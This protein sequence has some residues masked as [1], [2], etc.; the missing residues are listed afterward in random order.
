MISVSEF[1]QKVKLTLSNN[2][3]CKFW[4]LLGEGKKIAESAGET[5]SLG[6]GTQIN[7]NTVIDGILITGENCTIGPNAVIRG[8]AILGSNCTIKNSEVK[9]LVMLDNSKIPHFSTVGDSVFGEDVNL[10]AGTQIGNLR[11][12]N[13]NVKVTINGEKID[14]GQRK[15]GCLIGHNSKTGLNSSINCGVIVGKNCQLYPG[16]FLAHNLKDNEIFK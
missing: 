14:S 7:Q 15:L 1:L 4:E 2:P 16:K 12:D 6:K 8:F 5:K 9:N 3:E 11:F 10:G 13:G